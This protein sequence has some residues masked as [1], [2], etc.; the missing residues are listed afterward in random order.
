VE[1]TQPGGVSIPIESLA[2]LP[3]ACD[4]SSA[5]GGS[6]LRDL[7]HDLIEPTAVRWLV[8]AADAESGHDLR[9]PVVP[10]GAVRRGPRPSSSM[11]EGWNGAGAPAATALL[12]KPEGS[13]EVE[14]VQWGRM[15]MLGDGSGELSAPGDVSSVTMG[16]SL[17]EVCHDL[18]EPTATIRWLVR[19]AEAE[20]GEEL[21]DRLEAIA[22]AAGQIAAI[23]DD[24]L[25]RPQRCAGVRLDLLADDAVASA[26]VRYAGM[27]EISSQPVTALAGLGD[28]VRILTN[29]L[30]NACRA[31]GPAGRV[32]VLVDESDGQA[33]L[34]IDDSGSGLGHVVPGGRAGLG[35]EIIG[36]L[37]LEHGGSVRLG[38][39]DLGGLAVTVQV[40]AQG[41]SSN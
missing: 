31:A 7:C 2:D 13:E 39:S 40:P 24:I 23:C 3:A 15:G 22:V 8:R 26:Q 4:M 28:V 9:N 6:S 17:R 16:S 1:R 10:P 20:S 27:I 32:R 11:A 30:T 21:R 34:A 29:I 35:L 14:R 37:A 41:R 38:V 12:G 33:R 36:A 5:A 18:I 25:D 19:A